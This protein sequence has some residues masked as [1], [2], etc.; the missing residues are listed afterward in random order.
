MSILAEKQRLE[1]IYMYKQGTLHTYIIYFTTITDILLKEV[2]KRILIDKFKKI[3]RSL[4]VFLLF[5]SILYK[6]TVV[7]FPN[8]IGNQR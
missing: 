8:F 7:Y 6:F 5:F 3:Y 2:E 1:C 4:Q